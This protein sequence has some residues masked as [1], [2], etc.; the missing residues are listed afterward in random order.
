MGKQRQGL[1]PFGWAGRKT[2]LEGF[3]EEVVCA[4]G[5]ESQVGFGNVKERGSGIPEHALVAGKDHPQAREQG[6]ESGAPRG[7][8]RGPGSLPEAAGPARVGAAAARFTQTTRNDVQQAVTGAGPG[9]RWLLLRQV[10][11]RLRGR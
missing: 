3:V 1:T 7:T 2:I 10:S 8:E 5:L 11:L 6:A 4:L 9:K